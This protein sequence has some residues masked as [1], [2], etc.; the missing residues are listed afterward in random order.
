MVKV[1]LCTM[2][3]YTKMMLVSPFQAEIHLKAQSVVEI[4]CMKPSS[5]KV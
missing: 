4:R 1:E 2:I 3:F 5:L